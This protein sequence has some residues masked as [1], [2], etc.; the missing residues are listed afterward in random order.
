TDWDV[1]WSQ[2]YL[3]VCRG[4]QCLDMKKE[5][6]TLFHGLL[7]NNVVLITFS[8]SR[9]FNSRVQTIDLKITFPFFLVPV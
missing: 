9:N 5:A 6:L 3:L 4:K 8:S 1:V 2:V 7:Q